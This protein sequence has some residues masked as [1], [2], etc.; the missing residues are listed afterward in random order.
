MWFVMTFGLE[1]TLKAAVHDPKRFEKLLNKFGEVS[2]RDFIAWAQCDIKAFISHDDICMTEG[3]LFSPTW[4]RRHL[5]P[6]YRQIA[7]IARAHDLP[8]IFH[9][10]GD[11]RPVIPDLIE[12]GFHALH[13]IEPKAMDI[14]ELKRTYG[15]RLCLCGNI[16]LCYTLPR[17]TPEEVRAE[18][19][20]RIKDCGPRGGYCLGSANSVPEYV[21]LQNYLAM[22]DAWWDFGRY[23]LA[24][25]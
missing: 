22:L 3:P 25:D 14:V 19:R 15:G 12:M 6:W 17:G 2:V 18:V 7:E 9:S 10:D 4:L 13:P 8:M 23:P 1:W 16:D 11:I 21:P 24:L 20:Q 5:F